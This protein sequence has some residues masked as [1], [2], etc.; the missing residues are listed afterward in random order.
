MSRAHH[1]KTKRS[2]EE[3]VFKAG[4]Q[5]ADDPFEFVLSD[6]T[7]D[8]HGDIVRASG[9]KLSD[10]KKNPIALAGHNHDLRQVVGVWQNVRVVGK[11]LIGRLKLAEEG[12]SEVV[13]VAR[14]LL[15]QRIIK[16]V[17]VG[18]RVLEWEPRDEKE[19]WGGWD[20]S[21]AALHEVSLVAVP[22]NPNALAVAKAFSPKAADILFAEPGTAGSGDD[23]RQPAT[24]F[25][26]PN[27][28]AARLRAK[29]LGI[30][31]GI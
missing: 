28:D 30:D 7:V 23:T 24:H 11:Q 14:K 29:A 12:T 16:A 5:S 18:F 3:P 2:A 31:T 6:E 8:R 13:D 26:T 21:K 4:S 20:I 25:S 1:D 9:W 22:A 27:L 10:F 19:P 17:S 15:E